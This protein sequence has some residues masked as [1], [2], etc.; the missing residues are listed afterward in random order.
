[1]LGFAADLME[2]GKKFLNMFVEKLTSK[3]EA[4]EEAFF[5]MKIIDQTS[6]ILRSKLPFMERAELLLSAFRQG[7]ATTDEKLGTALQARDLG[8]K[9]HTFCATTATS[10]AVATMQSATAADIEGAPE[11]A[12]AASGL[13]SLASLD[14]LEQDL[15]Q[16]FSSW[17]SLCNDRGFRSSS[18][19]VKAAVLIHLRAAMYPQLLAVLMEYA[20]LAVKGVDARAKRES[21]RLREELKTE[22][23]KSTTLMEDRNSQIQQV[24]KLEEELKRAL[25]ELARLAEMKSNVQVGQAAGGVVQ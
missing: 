7:I 10:T 21:S 19:A 3:K 13:A 18:T 15:S 17:N 24:K 1:M 4:K 9:F 8:E 12:I 16:S 22:R 20:A 25:A 5:S 23:E 11:A 2:S 14:K 6:A